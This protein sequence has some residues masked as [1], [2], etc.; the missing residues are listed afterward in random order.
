MSKIFKRENQNFMNMKASKMLV[1]ILSCAL[2]IAALCSVSAFAAETYDSQCASHGSGE[3]MYDYYSSLY[4]S[5]GP[6]WRAAT[7]VQAQNGKTVP[8]GYLKA[9]AFLYDATGSL[10]K[11]TV[12]QTNTTAANYLVVV[13]PGLNSAGEY[14]SR[15]EVSLYLNSEYTTVTAPTL[16]DGETDVMKTIKATLDQDGSYPVNALGE[17]Y[18]SMLLSHVVGYK[19]DLIAAIGTNNVKGYVRTDELAPYTTTPDESVA[20][21]ASVK[22]SVL[23]LYDLNGKVIGTFVQDAGVSSNSKAFKGSTFDAARTK[24]AAGSYIT[25]AQ[26]A[27]LPKTDQELAALAQ[28]ALAITPY[29]RN[30]KGLTY[31][32]DSMARTVGY[33]PEL[34]AVMATNGTS[35]YAKKNEFYFTSQHAQQDPASAVISVYDLDGKVVGEFKFE[36]G[37]SS[38][39]PAFAGLSLEEVREKLAA[40]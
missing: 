21:A 35:G 26:T 8:A 9:Q 17:T 6:K 15:G 31:G 24:V 5:A 16:A 1:K 12:M 36:V 7:W 32:S 27:K 4:S 25:P 38:N 19:P 39:D 18:G 14:Y 33:S 3:Q 10:C 28:S 40:G 13:A 29:S 22:D 37:Q 11:S 34:I 20:L 23:P 30:S 2:S